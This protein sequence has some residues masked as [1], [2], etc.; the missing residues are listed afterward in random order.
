MFD[1]P[2]SL[3]TLPTV[4]LGVLSVTVTYTYGPQAGGQLGTYF[5]KA[6]IATGRHTVTALTRPGSANQLAAGVKAIPVDYNDEQTLIDALQNQQFLI[7]TLPVTVAPDT[8][9]KLVRA[10]AAAGVPYV[11]PSYYGSDVTNSALLKDDLLSSN[12]AQLCAEIEATGVSA[13]T[14][15]VCGLWYEYSIVLGPLCLGFDHA[16]KTMTFYDDGAAK[17]NLSTFEQCGRAVAGLLSL[18]ELPDDEGD[19]SPTVSSWRNKPLYVSSFLVSQRDMFESWKRATGETDADW[20]I[21]YESSQ[22]RYQ[23]GVAMMQGAADP[24]S[25]RM[26]A[27]LASFVRLFFPS[28]DGAYETTRVLANDALGLPKEDLDERTA[29]AKKMLDEGYPDWVFGRL[30]NASDQSQLASQATK[31]E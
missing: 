25:T 2:S 13:W 17:V 24:L 15:M 18:K 8:Q 19:A 27:A 20:T 21:E 7:I 23:R 9:S 12:G 26:G 28:G 4:S 5:A 10:A 22:A 14:A 29:V 16:N 1:R 6:L 30:R 3:A 11:M 31:K